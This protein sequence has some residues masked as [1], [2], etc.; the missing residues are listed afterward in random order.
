[1]QSIRG[2]WGDSRKGSYKPEGEETSINRYQI[3]FVRKQQRSLDNGRMRT[4]RVI[5]ILEEDA[6]QT[7]QWTGQIPRYRYAAISAL[8][9]SMPSSRAILL[10]SKL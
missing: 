3:D 6:T 5:W 2:I 1:M 9:H 10:Q 4:I 8:L 7:P